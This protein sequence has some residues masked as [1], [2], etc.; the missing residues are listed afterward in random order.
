MRIKS[1]ALLTGNFP[2]MTGG[3]S[4]YLDTIF[5]NLAQV[6]TTIICLPTPGW[7]TFDPQQNYRVRRINIPETWHPFYKQFKY[8]FPAYLAEL[9]KKRNLDFVLCGHAH[10]SLLLSAWI[11]SIVKKVPYGVFIYGLDICHVQRHNYK[12]VY[13]F[14]VKQ[15]KI[16]IACSQATARIIENLGIPAEKVVVINPPITFNRFTNNNSVDIIRKKYGLDG[17]KCILTVG[18][19]VKR[20]GHDVVLRALPRV[21][22][23][24]PKARYVIIGSGPNEN[25]LKSLVD[26]MGLNEH[27]IF[28]GHVSD[29][30]L[31]SFYSASDIFIMASREIPEEGDIEGFGIVYLEANLFEKPVIA[32]RSGGIADAVIHEET[33]LLVD[34][35]NEIEVAEAIIRLLSD[36][37][38]TRRLGKRGRERVLNK[39]TVEQAAQ[40]LIR[41][42]NSVG[43]SL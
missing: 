25:H 1:I 12:I 20:K 38:L 30:E 11:Y 33:G 6:H 31:G 26:R 23:E 42:L 36:P 18:H 4:N 35:N 17:R 28:V 41:K 34:P 24:F 43:D 7:G 29:N 37:L 2:P 9:F 21:L 22:E 32:G 40:K 15:A 8:L 10:H 19:L 16:V 27:V 39:F 13:N 3:I 14:L 5:K